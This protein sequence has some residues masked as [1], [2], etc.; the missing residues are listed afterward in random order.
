MGQL[1]PCSCARVLHLICVIKCPLSLTVIRINYRKTT[2]G[3]SELRNPDLNSIRFD[4]RSV[5]PRVR[6]RFVYYVVA[7]VGAFRLINSAPPPRIMPKITLEK[8]KRRRP[9]RD[10]HPARPLLAFAKIEMSVYQINRRL[11]ARCLVT[12]SFGYNQFRN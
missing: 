9:L 8:N 2:P 6:I 3:V 11:D 1:F 10:Q 7:V 12:N 4:F 5:L